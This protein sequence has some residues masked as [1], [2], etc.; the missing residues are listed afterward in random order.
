MALDTKIR[1]IMPTEYHLLEDFIYNAIYLPPGTEFPPREIIFEPE[2]FIYIKGFGGKDDCGVVAEINEKIIGAAWV[3][4]IPA[5][6]HIDS[7]TPELAISVLS[8]YRSQGVGTMM[9]RHLFELLRSR[10]YRR[11]SLS[12][13]KDNPAV[14]LY[15]RLGYEITGEK[16][17]HAGH[18]DYIMVKNLQLL[19]MTDKERALL[20]PVILCEHNPAWA[21][22][23]QEEKTNLENLI[24]SGCIF[25]ITHYGSTAVPGLLAKPT[26]DILLEINED[27]DGFEHQKM[28]HKST[29]DDHNVSI[30]KGAA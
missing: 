12:V 3:R 30:A 2:I 19:E 21:E 1:E 4:I 29:S 17:D 11:T 5:F 16:T 28:C 27:T 24:G 6:G 10:G 8:E 22:W 13:Q 23:F 7:K 26:V 15:K 14:R 25:R 9:M 18:E 20:F